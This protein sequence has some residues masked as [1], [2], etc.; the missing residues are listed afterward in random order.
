MT[1]SLDQILE[2]IKKTGDRC[3]VIDRATENN[4]VVMSIKDYERLALGSSP[5][6]A[7]Q[8]TAA[9]KLEKIAVK[10]EIK[11]SILPLGAVPIEELS[12][13]ARPDWWEEETEKPQPL[14]EKPNEDRYYLEPVES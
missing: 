13:S 14:E 3:V 4:Y 2:L 7:Q 6:P 9:E 12:E 1:E 10:E 5:L 8:E 11:Q